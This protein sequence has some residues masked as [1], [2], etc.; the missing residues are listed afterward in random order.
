MGDVVTAKVT[1]VNSRQV[2]CTI[3]C[4][5][6]S[7]LERTYR[8]IIRKEDIRKQIQIVDPYKCFR[9]GDIILAKVVS[10]IKYV[11]C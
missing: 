3:L 10:F 2:N 6:P 7:V 4:V 8:G 1:V 9:P 5:G 11:L